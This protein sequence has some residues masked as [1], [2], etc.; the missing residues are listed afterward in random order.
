M[1]QEDQSGAGWVRED[2]VI[3]PVVL[4]DS[5]LARILLGT[6]TLGIWPP[7]LSDQIPYPPPSI[8]YHPALHSATIL[9]GEFTQNPPFHWC[10]LLVIFPPTT[11]PILPCLPLVS[12]KSQSIWTSSVSLPSLETPCSRI[13]SM[14]LYIISII[15]Y[16][17]LE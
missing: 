17:P 8:S 15:L 4:F 11:P 14:I 16:S 12:C 9:S 13:I 7:M 6:P 5:S 3:S 2:G 1:L 10:F